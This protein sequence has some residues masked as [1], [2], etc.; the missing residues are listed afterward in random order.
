M[1]KFFGFFGFKSK[2]KVPESP[3]STRSTNIS[4]LSTSTTSPKRMLA[5]TITI[6]GENTSLKTVVWDGMT[7]D[8]NETHSA[9]D[10]GTQI[11]KKLVELENCKATFQYLT[12]RFA[13]VPPELGN[14]FRKCDCFV[15]CFDWSAPDPILEISNWIKYG[16]QY[17]PDIV[18]ILIGTNS[19]HLMIDEHKKRLAELERLKLSERVFNSMELKEGY[20][21]TLSKT[22]TMAVRMAVQECRVAEE[23]RRKRMFFNPTDSPEWEF[24]IIN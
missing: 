1:K 18:F 13:I 16:K 23:V 15:V 3:R 8:S 22:M 20:H 19:Q 9:T 6:V 5:Y 4:N 12:P 2:E 14:E 10:N 24:K 21:K 17:N 11:I 7:K